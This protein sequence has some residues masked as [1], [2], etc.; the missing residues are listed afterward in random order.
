MSSK[1]SSTQHS[2]DSQGSNMS[3]LEPVPEASFSESQKGTHFPIILEAFNLLSN[4]HS[5]STY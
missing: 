1:Q 2:S 4:F 5:R 3:K